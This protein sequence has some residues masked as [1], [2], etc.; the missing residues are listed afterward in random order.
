MQIDDRVYLIHKVGDDQDG[1][2][3]LARCKA[4]GIDTSLV[5]AQPNL[6][7][8]FSYMYDSIEYIYIFPS[9]KLKSLCEHNKTE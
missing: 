5:V 6:Q 1:K 8:A 3:V 2:F 7:T 4:I 9:K